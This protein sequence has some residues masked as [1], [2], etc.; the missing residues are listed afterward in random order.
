MEDIDHAVPPAVFVENKT[1]GM[2]WD[3]NE[4]QTAPVTADL[5]NYNK[6]FPKSEANL[7]YIKSRISS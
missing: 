1:E 2:G 5:Q 7:Y 3:D 4:D 6:E